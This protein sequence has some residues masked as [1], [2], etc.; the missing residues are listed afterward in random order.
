TCSAL[1]AAVDKT[2]LVNGSIINLSLNAL[3]Q[4]APSPIDNI[5]SFQSFGITDHGFSNYQAG[6]VTLNKSLSR[7]LQLQ[8]TWTWSHAIGNQGVDQQSGSSA[9]SPYNLLLDKASETFDRRHTVNFWWYYELPFGRTMRTSSNALNRLIGGWGT[10]GI[11][12]Y[13]TGTPLHVSAN[14]DYGAF[15]SNGTAAICSA[16]LSGLAGLHAN[17][18]CSRGIG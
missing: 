14:G 15:E 6:F 11:F 3:N 16:D 18:T 10:S 9:N 5:Q 12:T 13:S 7:G 8:A 4:L 1:L 2:D 17:V